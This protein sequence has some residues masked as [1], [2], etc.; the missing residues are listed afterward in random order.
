V[1]TSDNPTPPKHISVIDQEGVRGWIE[2][3]GAEAAEA[4]SH[5]TVRT[6]DGRVFSVPRELLVNQKHG[7]YALTGSFADLSAGQAA[8]TGAR[9][10]L[11]ARAGAAPREAIV[12]LPVLTEKLTVIKRPVVTGRL[13]VTKRVRSHQE[14]IE[15]TVQIERAEV[16]RVP[17]D[18]II[19]IAP[20]IRYENDTMVI[21]VVEEVLVVE[22][23]LMLREELRISKR[24]LEQ[25]IK[26]SVSLRSEEVTVERFDSE[27]RKNDGDQG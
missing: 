1:S 20:E 13:R 8:H 11:T 24:Q 3:G 22:K 14:S 17:I 4:A 5:L 26:E 21:S 9:P 16:E 23:R 6:D 7:G 10:H 12:V 27:G 19:D 2:E 25:R 15:E 18:R